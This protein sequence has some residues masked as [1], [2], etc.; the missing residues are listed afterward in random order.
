MSTEQNDNLKINKKKLGPIP[1]IESMELR[2]YVSPMRR[3][4]MYFLKHKM[5]VLSLIVLLILILASI[6]GPIIS[7]YDPNFDMDFDSIN[8]P[9]N[10]QHWLG[11][12][13]TGRDVL[14]RLLYAGRISLSIGFVSVSIAV[15]IGVLVG[16]IAGYYGG[17]IDFILQRIVD[18]AMAL[19]VLMMVIIVVGFLGANI[20]N[21]MI[22]IGLT[23]WMGISRLVRSQVL[24]IRESDYVLAARCIG[25]KQRRI[26]LTC[27]LPNVLAPVIV[28]ATFGMAAAILIESSLSFLGIGVQIPNATWGNMLANARN[29]NTLREWYW[30]WVP[31][32]FAITATVL[33]INFV[34]DAIRDIM[35]PKLL[36]S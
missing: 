23:G 18:T 16:L 20:Y 27:I 3:R 17:K 36:N 11:T 1:E 10:M 14:T 2:T 12:D 31:P 9:P 19:P 32:G 13:G 26:L 6:L 8:K 29:L 28:A 22:V 15:S 30:L 21:I 35:D 25:L 34:G 4:W 5:A 7:P 33:C 24:Y